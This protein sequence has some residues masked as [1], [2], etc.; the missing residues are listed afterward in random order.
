MPIQANSNLSGEISVIFCI[1]DYLFFQH[2]NHVYY[3]RT[4]IKH[5][6]S[7]GLCIV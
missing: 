2:L 6:C 7:L 5:I 3:A 1:S 4:V